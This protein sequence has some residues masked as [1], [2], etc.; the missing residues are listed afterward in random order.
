MINT[1]LLTDDEPKC[2]LT[3][4]QHLIWHVDQIACLLFFLTQMTTNKNK[5]NVRLG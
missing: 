5:Q 3:E 4:F 2:K 1:R